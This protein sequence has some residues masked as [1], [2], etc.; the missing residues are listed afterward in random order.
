MDRSKIL[1]VDDEPNVTAGLKRV[2]RQ[3]PYEIFTADSAAAA[4]DV[5]AKQDI[6][7]V[8][9]DERM[10][11]M[12]GSQ[13]LA[14]VRQQYPDTVRII[15]SGQA[16][17]E[18]AVRAINEGE[19]YRFFIKPL[20]AADLDA[21]IRQ[22][23]QHKQLEKQS[24][25]LLREY[26]KQVSMIEELE[27]ANPGITALHT[28][29]EGAILVEEEDDTSLDALLQEMERETRQADM[30][31]APMPPKSVAVSGR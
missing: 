14:L 6:D 9:S 8:I 29:E 7:V 13:F 15:L 30:Q 11:G 28:D 16:N 5:L 27:R 21:T 3:Q 17:L 25:R 1:F 24:R 19:I 23:L 20:N 31:R 10:P 18:D 26:Q 22:S 12:S 2:L 4:L